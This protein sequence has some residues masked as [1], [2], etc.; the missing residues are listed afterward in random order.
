K[1]ITRII[2]GTLRLGVSD[3][4]ILDSI[5][6]A[7]CG[8]KSI[9]KPLDYIFGVRADIGEITQLSLSFKNGDEFLDG[10]KDITVKPGTPM[11][12]KLVEREASSAAVWERMP[13]CFVQPKLDGLRG[14]IHFDG[15]N[16]FVFS[17][18]M[19]NMTEH[20][21]EL[22]ES[23]KALKVKSIILDSEIK[24]GRASCRERV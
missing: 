22:I 8:D 13:M 2:L 4:T 18:N 17:R 3:K 24:I 23:V 15:E 11:A 19:E 1:Y 9:R 21:P 5:S 16:G 7:I 6:W 12:S 20:F 10:I 14:Q